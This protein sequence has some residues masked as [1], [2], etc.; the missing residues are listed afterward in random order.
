MYIVL[1]EL[2]TNVVVST[3]FILAGLF[4]FYNKLFNRQ[5]K[6]FGYFLVLNVV[7]EI[8][9]W[10]SPYIFIEQN[11]LPGLHLYTLLEFILITLFA[12][13]NFEKLQGLPANIILIAG[14]LL[15][16]ANSIWIQDIYIFN[17]ISITAVKIFTSVISI[18]FF[19]KV[20]SSKKYSIVETRPSVYFFTAIFLNACT[21]MIWY[22]YSNK[23]IL[24]DKIMG[25]Q[26]SILKHS[27]A[28]I[29]SLIILT[30]IIYIIKRKK[31]DII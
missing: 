18:L 16:I 14:S 25:R 5:E 30:G 27:V 22:M 19:F 2:L 20:L 31:N 6:I 8:I 12:A 29:S 15:I 28:I 21:S 26:L 11:N 4:I 9:A 10:A 23:F 3:S 17:S 13:S 1:T 7:F 24:L